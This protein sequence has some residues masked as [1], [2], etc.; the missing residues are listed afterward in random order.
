MYTNPL[1]VHVCA[2]ECMFLPI[3][4][5]LIWLQLAAVCMCVFVCACL[6]VEGVLLPELLINSGPGPPVGRSHQ[7]ISKRKLVRQRAS[8]TGCMWKRNLILMC[9]HR[10]WEVILTHTWVFLVCILEVA[11]LYWWSSSKHCLLLL[12]FW[13]RKSF[14]FINLNFGLFE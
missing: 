13:K 6:K 14:L 8:Q 4:R 10:L 9:T 7:Q 3:S 12:N 11:W 1:C 5:S 2:S